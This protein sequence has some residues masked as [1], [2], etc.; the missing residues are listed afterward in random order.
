VTEPGVWLIDP[1][2]DAE[3]L[4][5]VAALGAPAG[6]LQLLDR[7]KRDCAAIASRL[8]VP[9]LNVPDDVP[10][11]PF[12]VIRVVRRPGWKESALWWPERRVLVVAEALGTTEHFT[13]GQGPVGVHPML[14]L[15]PPGVLREQMPDHLLVGHGKGVHGSHTAAAIEHALETARSGAPK[16]IVRLGALLVGQATRR[17][18]RSRAR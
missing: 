14:R 10:G 17:A 12:E 6:V 18:T 1:V 5:R 4:E 2:D 11:S 13:L 9:H 3:A 16:A 8:D 7:H 15:T